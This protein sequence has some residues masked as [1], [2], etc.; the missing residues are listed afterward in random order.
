MEK[1]RVPPA[2]LPAHQRLTLAEEQRRA[3]E[4]DRKR[5]SRQGELGFLGFLFRN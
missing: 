1:D 4:E 3:F 5:G 2:G